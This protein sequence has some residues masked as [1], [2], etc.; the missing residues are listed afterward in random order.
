MR[1][2]DD[3]R[4]D[5]PAVPA[6]PPRPQTPPRPCPECGAVAFTEAA[7]DGTPLAPGE[8]RCWGYDHVWRPQLPEVVVEAPNTAAGPWHGALAGEERGMVIWRCSHDHARQSR[9]MRCGS[10]ELE[11]RRAADQQLKLEAE[12]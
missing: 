6:E 8:R 11:R 10:A 7:R 2:P 4:R 5:D 3:R 12:R 1:P 9:A